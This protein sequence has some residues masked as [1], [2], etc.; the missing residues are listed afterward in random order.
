MSSSSTSSSN[1]SL[2][3]SNH[4]DHFHQNGKVTSSMP[5]AN[6]SAQLPNPAS[7]FNR[8]NANKINSSTKHNYSQYDNNIVT[9]SM[10]MNMTSYQDPNITLYPSEN[11]ANVNDQIMLNS[12]LINQNPNNNLINQN[13]SNYFQQKVTSK[14]PAANASKSR[15]AARSTAHSHL[16]VST[17]QLKD[18]ICEVCSDAASG[19]H[20]GVYSCE[21]CKAFFKRSTQG[22]TP[23]YVCPAT[24]TCTIDKQRRKSCQSCRLMKCFTVGMT[25]TSNF[26]LGTLINM[27]VS[28]ISYFLF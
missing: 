28:K 10:Q 13:Q 5:K 19:Y 27:F 26:L 1:S 20:Y 24:N 25:K 14:L 9:G 21:G 4:S 11:I 7:N 6:F 8:L 22:D 23:A 16:S 18:K 2:S 3:V 15:I 17:E 12:N